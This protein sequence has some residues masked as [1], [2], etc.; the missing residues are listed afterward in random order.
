MAGNPHAGPPT[1]TVELPRAIDVTEF[2]IDPSAGCGDGPSATTREFTIETSANGTNFQVAVDGIGANGFTDADIGA[3]N[4]RTPAAGTGTG[5][6]FVRIKLLSPLRA[7]PQCAPN[8]CSGSDFIDLSELEVLGGPPNALP[9]GNLATD[10]TNAQPGDS[11]H[12]DASSF[13]DP[14]SKITGYDW[15]FDGNGTI[16]RTT[17]GPATDFAYGGTGSF[18]ARVFVK[19][20]RGGAGTATQTILVQSPSTPT[21]RPPEL[22]I[23]Q[24]G[25]GR[26]IVIDVHCFDPPCAAIGNLKLSRRLAKRLD[27]GSRRV[28]DFDTTVNT[29][30]VTSIVAEVPRRVMR[31]A[32]KTALD[33]L[34]VTVT[35]AATDAGGQTTRAQR[36]T[37]LDL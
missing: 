10:K 17:D 30:Q 31:R 16:D 18:N 29:T 22:R 6:R 1:L 9:A 25:L 32:T 36:V 15:D 2:L 20:F 24:R 26:A 14:D 37:K 27:V 11:I 35:A 33:H 28:A 23:P 3:L 5:V 21:P 8:H 4:S 12:F 13:T 19:D 7:D 34:R